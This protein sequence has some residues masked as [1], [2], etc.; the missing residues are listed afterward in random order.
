VATLLR[1]GWRPVSGTVQV[2]TY[3]TAAST[4][5]AAWS[6]YATPTPVTI[7]A[8]TNLNAT[9]YPAWVVPGTGAQTGSLVVSNTAFTMTG[10]TITVNAPSVIFQGCSFASSAVP[11]V[12]GPTLINTTG[13]GPYT[14]NYCSAY[15]SDGTTATRVMLAINQGAD[16]AYTISNCNMYYM[17]QAVQLFSG[18]TAGVSITGNYMHDIVNYTTAAPTPSVSWA[19]TGGTVL[20]GTYQVAVTY[21]NA[22]TGETL[23]SVTPGSVTTTGSTSTITIT[24]PAASTGET[25]W[26]AYV[27]QANGASFTRQQTSGSPTAIGTSLTLTAPPTSSGAGVPSVDHSEHI[28][29]GATGGCSNIT[30]SGNTLLNPL[31]QTA[32][33]YL[34]PTYNFTSCAVTGNLMAGGDYCIYAGGSGSTGIVMQNNVFSTVSPYYANSGFFDPL[35]T[36]TPPVWG[37]SGNIWAGNTW[38]DGALAGQT[39]AST[40]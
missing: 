22:A 20:A 3:P 1:G 2:P 32:C 5:P 29:A 34:H 8:N 13:A 14:F 7:S 28:Y 26:Y 37:S 11:G 30:I 21:S 10:G 35:Y 40:L 9:G 25:G 16:A 31:S 24:S 15:G 18:T 27:T 36:G 12:N 17:K 39:I 6:G 33:V 38:Y 4:G 23:C 19:S